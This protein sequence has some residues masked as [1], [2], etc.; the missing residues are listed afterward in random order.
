MTIPPPL[1][2]ARLVG[3]HGSSFTS[4]FGLRHADMPREEEEPEPD[5]ED[6][7]HLD[8]QRLEGG[9][10][11]ATKEADGVYR[12]V[13]LAMHPMTYSIVRPGT[14]QKA[15][16]PAEFLSRGGGGGPSPCQVVVSS[17]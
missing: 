4:G 9:G 8:A 10:A 6:A 11:G 16:R 7:D 1:R 13:P 3:V 12:G 14:L 15:H 5:D 17:W 2:P